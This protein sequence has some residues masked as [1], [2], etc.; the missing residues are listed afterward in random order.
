M[1]ARQ[2]AISEL[3]LVIEAGFQ[4]IVECTPISCTARCLKSGSW[5]VSG[6]SNW[7]IV[8]GLVYVFFQDLAS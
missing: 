3:T 6:S 7:K 4:V 5:T 1:I 2:C 8:L